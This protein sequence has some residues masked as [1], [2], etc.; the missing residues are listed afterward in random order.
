MSC[1][2]RDWSQCKICEHYYNETCDKIVKKECSFKPSNDFIQFLAANNLQLSNKDNYLQPVMYFVEK[3]FDISLI[4][5]IPEK[6]ID[7]RNEQ[8]ENVISI[9]SSTK[10]GKVVFI[11]IDEE[12]RDA[13][14]NN[15][16]IMKFYFV[17]MALDK[18][19]ATK[20]TKYKLDQ[21]F[22]IMYF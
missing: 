6:I 19:Y 4:E 11:S 18:K 12:Y 15:D 7:L 10:F 22:V 16:W 3:D 2:K 5:E 17:R 1:I 13:I 8:V 21:R 9:L 20:Y 14:Y